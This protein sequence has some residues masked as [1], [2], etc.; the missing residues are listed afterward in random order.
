MGRGGREVYQI[1]PE[2]CNLHGHCDPSISLP[3]HSIRGILKQFTDGRSI[4]DATT[5][6]R[7]DVV[8][9][10]T[11]GERDNREIVTSDSI[12]GCYAPTPSSRRY[13]PTVIIPFSNVGYNA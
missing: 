3:P 13:A 12:L 1:T 5:H 7:M 8:N 9:K 10:E 6:R 4:H 2:I 11:P